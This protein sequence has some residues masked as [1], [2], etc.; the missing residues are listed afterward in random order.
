MSIWL[1]NTS[2]VIDA[3][4]GAL[5]EAFKSNDEILQKMLATKPLDWKCEN[6]IRVIC[7]ATSPEKWRIF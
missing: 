7:Q 3:Y 1:L 2:A 5:A 6:E 4:E